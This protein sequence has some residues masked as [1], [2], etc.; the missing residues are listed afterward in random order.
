M[1]EKHTPEPWKRV[2]RF[3]GQRIYQIEI[4]GPTDCGRGHH[5]ICVLPT[6]FTNQEADA[7]LLLSAPAIKRERDDLRAKLEL[8]ER[9]I[10]GY[11]DELNKHGV[12]SGAYF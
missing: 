9:Q 6:G 3:A 1:A 10:Q 7:E 12:G 5:P 8:A 2:N 4:V 11:K